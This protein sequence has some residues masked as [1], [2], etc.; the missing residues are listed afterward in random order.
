MFNKEIDGYME[1][2]AEHIT[3]KTQ[4]RL[5]YAEAKAKLTVLIAKYVKT[6]ASFE[7]KIPVLLNIPEISE[8]AQKLSETYYIN[9]ALWKNF[10]DFADL[11]K[12]KIIE[13]QSR[14]KSSF[15]GL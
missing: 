7:N 4:Y 9:E 12:T 2:L 8:E 6:S 11:Y 10:R 5:E 1:R 14:R 15:Q 3:K 13:C